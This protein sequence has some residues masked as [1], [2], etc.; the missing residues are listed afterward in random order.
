MLHAVTRSARRRKQRAA[1]TAEG[2]DLGEVPG[3]GVARALLVILLLHIAAIAGIWLHNHYN[4]DNDL[5]AVASS[6]EEIIP[7]KA[8]P[9]LERR[10]ASAGDTYTSLAAKWNVEEAEL[11][12]VNVP[13]Q[14][15]AEV[16]E[17]STVLVDSSHLARP[18]ETPDIQTSE[19]VRV[20]P[21]TNPAELVETVPPAPVPVN[22]QPVRDTPPEVV[23]PDPPVPSI[24]THTVRRGETLWRIAKNNGLTVADLMK[25]NPNVEARS[26]KPG[27]RLVIPSR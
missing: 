21:A 9:G 19:G 12:R 22:E 24:R 10:T 6:N 25:A 3:V 4:K 14:R 16:P 27:L 7:P 1:T 15:P 17:T 11:R 20:T 18:T 8:I 13:K 2:E 5:V 23:E 26:M